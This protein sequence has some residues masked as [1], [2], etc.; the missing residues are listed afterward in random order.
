MA[1]LEPVSL[2]GQHARLEPL[3]HEHWDGLV[4]AV[5]D[6]ELWKLW[7]TFIPRAEDMKKEIDR[8][9]GLQAAGSM[10]P[11]TVFD[12]D[13]RIAGMTTYMNVDAANRRVEI[14][15]TWY[16]R[17]VQRSALNTQCK[18]LLLTQAFEKLDCI[19]VEFRTH[20]FNHQ[21]R[22][23][24]E[25]LGAKQDGTLRNHQIASNGTL[26]DT[27]VYSIIASEWPTVKA[28]LDYQLNEK[29]R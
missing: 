24:I 22:R 8:R 3:S 25:R 12:A 26:R 2:K 7:Y 17:R 15:S 11:W 9:L 13:G 21:S 5:Q 18:C 16:A 6:G 10:L 4:D 14:G 29:A 20:F 19:A 23:G 1:W 27:V 28:H